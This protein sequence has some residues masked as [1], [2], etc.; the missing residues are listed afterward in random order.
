MVA[1]WFEGSAGGK[2]EMWTF[3]Y[4]LI[5]DLLD[6]ACAHPDAD[7]CARLA[8]VFR[9][10]AAHVQAEMKCGTYVPRAE[11][12]A[13]LHELQCAVRSIA[14]SHKVPLPWLPTPSMH[15]MNDEQVFHML[16][17]LVEALDY[18]AKRSARFDK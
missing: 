7:S 9:R 4:D 13:L 16:T 8:D 3:P 18:L 11:T 17:G 6:A 5:N 15:E 12:Q 1:G 10:M 14:E 2:P